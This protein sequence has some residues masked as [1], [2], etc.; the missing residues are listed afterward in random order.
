MRPT[1]GVLAGWQVYETV[2]PVSFLDPVLR[3]IRAAARETGC[4]ILLACGMGPAKN[5]LGIRPAW[6]LVSP[7]SD[8]VPVGPENTDGLIVVNPLLLPE[9]AH[10][11]HELTAGGFPVVFVGGAEGSL[12]VKIDNAGGIRQ[13]LEHL[14]EH[15]HRR[16][17]FIA[18]HPQDMTGDTG[19]RLAAYQAFIEEHSLPCD[20][21]LIAYGFHIVEGGYRAMREILQRRV[22]FTAVVASNDESAVG[23]LQALREAG[24]RIP[25]D[26]ALV[27]FDD[28]PEAETE[29]PPLTSV[30]HSPFRLGYQALKLLLE[31]IGGTRA[32]QEVRIATRLVVRRSCGCT[33]EHVIFDLPGQTAPAENRD[34]AQRRCTSLLVETVLAETKSIHRERAHALSE[35]LVRAFTTA[36]EHNTPEVFHQALAEAIQQTETLDDNIH[37]WQHVLTVLRSEV[38]TLMPPGSAMTLKQVEDMIHSA[39]VTVSASVRRQHMNHLVRQNRQADLAGPLTV[40]LSSALDESEIFTALQEHLPRLGIRHMGL[41]LFEREENDPVAWSTLRLVTTPDKPVRFP[42]REFPPPGLFDEPFRLALLPLVIQNEQIGFVAFDADRL[43]LGGRI[44]RELAGALRSAHLYR[45]AMEGRRLAEEANRL[46][47][48]LLSTVSHELRTP[49]SLIVT[50]SQMLLRN[51]D[52]TT[53]PESFRRDLERIYASAQ[54]LDS[55]IRDVL[56]L[57]Q[58]EIGQLRLVYEPLDMH[59]VVQPVVL[60]GELMAKD[61]GLK[62]RAEIANDLP[63]VWGDRTRLR[64]VILNLVTNAIKFTAQGE[65]VLRVEAENGAVKISV[66]DT[67]LGI[68]PEEQETIFDEFRQ[69]SRTIARGYGGLG[70]GLA[71]C[72]RLVEM[73]GGRIGVCS[74]GEEGAGSTF[75]FTLPTLKEEALPPAKHSAGQWVLLVTDRP[76]RIE[77]LR[78]HLADHGE[79]VE[80]RPPGERNIWLPQVM[81]T[82]PVAIVLDAESCANQSWE[83]AKVLK[84]NPA[85]REIP[86]IFYSLT[87][88]EKHGSVLEMEYLT[89]PVGTAELARALE[90]YGLLERKGNGGKTILVVDDEPEILEAHARIVES[91]APDYR[92]LKARNGREA[93]EIVQQEQPDLVLLDLMMPEMDGFQVLEE[94]RRRETTRTVPVIVLTAKVLT[95]EDMARL[96]QGVAVVL[97]KG[98]FSVEEMLAH[99]AQTLARTRKV[100]NEAQRLVR[101]AMAYIHEHYAE[102][103]S[104]EEIAAHVGVSKDYLTRIFRQETGL[105][106]VAYLN[107][108]RVHQAKRLLAT[109][110]KTVHEIAFEVGFS[111]SEYFSHVF[112]KETGMSP[113]AYRERLAAGLMPDYTGDDLAFISSSPSPVD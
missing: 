76:E 100:G 6:P 99:I 39:R 61:K 60:V 43:E 96:S 101:R 20:S 24:L 50:L 84:E 59:E 48:R 104:R 17:A 75:Y 15:G 81:R 30:H 2:I 63:P 32:T 49:L 90:R 78:A 87:K 53:L 73:H 85:T 7:D 72:K 108:Y 106:P 21:R 70:L 93:L 64:Q 74:S 98:V 65:V 52:G 25:E 29:S 45:E 11:V 10:Y 1:I 31:H 46:K 82:P 19:E 110:H 14:L 12:A 71:I 16:I 77:R 83:T 27:G 42:S 33:L 107:R 28:T 89:K 102:P 13:A 40:H 67:G 94:M 55:L 113:S 69:S 9:R 92:V 54:H 80:V 34:Q 23:A 105:T 26:V 109:T 41:A 79:T 86:V 37:A 103:I 97:E 47:S 58:S 56:D 62:W 4:N 111:S 91:Q 35:H 95:E 44:V 8:F 57:A 22:P 66:S 88:D 18:G 51:G 5:P 112:R 36:V 38:P 68:P 3:G